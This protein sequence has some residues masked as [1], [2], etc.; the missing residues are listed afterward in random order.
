MTNTD[1]YPPGTPRH[2]TITVPMTGYDGNA[3]AILGRVNAALR[4]AGATEPERVAFMAQAT[5]GDYDTL[6]RTCMEWVNVT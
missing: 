5:S 3:I 4:N 2:A 1:R 6:L